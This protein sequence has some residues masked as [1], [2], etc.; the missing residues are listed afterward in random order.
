MN[1]DNL[2]ELHW[3]YG[4]HTLWGIVITFTVSLLLFMKHKR[5]L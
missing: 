1:F 2:P 4:Y 3:E 5:W